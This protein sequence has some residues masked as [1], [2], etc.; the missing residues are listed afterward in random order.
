MYNTTT[1]LDNKLMEAFIVESTHG[2]SLD[3]NFLLELDDD[4]NIINF[5]EQGATYCLESKGFLLSDKAEPDSEAGAF[6]AMMKNYFSI[7]MS[8]KDNQKIPAMSYLYNSSQVD[9]LIQQISMLA[10]HS[11]FKDVDD[12]FN[13]DKNI[14]RRSISPQSVSNSIAL[15]LYFVLLVNVNMDA[16]SYNELFIKGWYN[17][18]ANWMVR[19][20]MFK[21]NG[22]NW[23]S[24]FE[25]VLLG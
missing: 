16:Y 24:Q 12:I 22:N 4:P 5:Q 1:E 8:N 15:Y 3:N 6:I 13:V 21:M 9:H 7:Y 17:Y 25:G 20:Q 10:M 19:T 14:L 11:Q 23:K 2:L 18:Y